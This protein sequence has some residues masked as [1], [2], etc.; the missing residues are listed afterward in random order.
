MKNWTLLKII[1]AWL[2]EAKGVWLEEL[3]NVFWAYMTTTRTPTGET[4]FN[5][6]YGTEIVIPIEVGITSLRQE[7]FHEGNNDNQLRVNLD[8]LDE[9]K[10]GASHKMVKYQQKMSK[11]Y[12]RRV[13]LRRLNT[14]D[15]VLRKVTPATKNPTQGKL[16][17]T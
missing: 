12:N 11:F 5:L 16:D 13:K 1:K 7:A 8:C 10:D 2:D 9:S 3:P 6:T 14:G 17:P 4:P 15:L